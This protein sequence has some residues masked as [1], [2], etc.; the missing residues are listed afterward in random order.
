MGSQSRWPMCILAFE[1]VTAVGSILSQAGAWFLWDEGETS[2]A[3]FRWMESLMFSMPL[4]RQ[5]T[6]YLREN[7]QID[8][9]PRCGKLVRVSRHR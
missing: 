3:S 6:L 7:V 1:C 8:K 4:A 5:R 9:I 2:S